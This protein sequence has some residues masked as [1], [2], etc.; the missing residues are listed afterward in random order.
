MR[1][2]LHRDAELASRRVVSGLQESL[3]QAVAVPRDMYRQLRHEL[4]AVPELE[5][6]LLTA[7]DTK[8][9]PVTLPAA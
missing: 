8:H 2:R 9:I 1:L 3:G 7:M 4:R 5:V 6:E